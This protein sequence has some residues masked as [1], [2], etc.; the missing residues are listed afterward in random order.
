MIVPFNVKALSVR[1]YAAFLLLTA[2]CVD[3]EDEVGYYITSGN[4][5]SKHDGDV[6]NRTLTQTKKHWLQLAARLHSDG[7]ASRTAPASASTPKQAKTTR[8]PQRTTIEVNNV[9]ARL[10]VATSSPIETTSPPL[11]PLTFP[12]ETLSQL[13]AAGLTVPKRHLRHRHDTRRV[14][15][16]ISISPFHRLS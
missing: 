3:G 2:L 8:F 4:G 5:E 16:R 10:P 6:R 1:L 13:D 12:G 11:S 9:L 14:S 15:I 7:V